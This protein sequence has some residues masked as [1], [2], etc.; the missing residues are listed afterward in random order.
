M[1]NDKVEKKRVQVT[2]SQQL[3]DSLKT[4]GDSIGVSVPSLLVLYATEH[5]KQ[6][7][8]VSILPELLTAYSDEVKRKPD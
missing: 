2:L 6:N 3:Y 8:M 4:Y 5:M 1:D 7:Q